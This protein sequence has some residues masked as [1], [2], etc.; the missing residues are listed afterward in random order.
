[1]LTAQRSSTELQHP[2]NNLQSIGPD[3]EK[4]RAVIER[5]ET[6]DGLYVFGVRSTGI[7][8]KP[9]CPSRHPNLKQVVFFSR[10]DEA[11]RS[12]FRSCKRCHPR[13]E[14][15]STKAEIV[16]RICKF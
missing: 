2:R 8:C 3:Q 10:P 9:S 6:K 4:W 12:G 15:S 7:Y 14:R 16:Q 13:D 1:M 5:D 11:E